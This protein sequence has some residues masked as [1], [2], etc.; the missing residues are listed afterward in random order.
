MPRTLA[1]ALEMLAE[2]APDGMPIAGGTNVI[3]DLRGGRYRPACL[4]NVAGLP[5]LGGIRQEDGILVIGGGVTVAEV[6]DDPLVA[7]YAPVLREAARTLASPLVRNRATVAGNLANASPAAD[8]APPLLVLDAEVELASRE[9]TRRVPLKDFFLGVR[10]T[11][12]QP[13]EL[14]TA[15]RIPLPPAHSRARFFKV[16]LRKANAIAVVNSAVRVDWEYGLGSREYGLGGR[17]YGWGGGLCRAARIALGAVAPTPIR[18]WEAERAL[19]GQ[20]LMPEVIA[21]AARLA[22][23]ATRTIDDIRG[24]AAY[25]RHVTEV[26]VRRALEG[27]WSRE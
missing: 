9:G 14:I 22:A 4:V 6:L 5:E 24:S 17:E 10:R 20:S 3:P 23:E 11:V 27:L 18:A 19:E 12:R 1:E 26:L 16:A 21:Q 7:R 8:M 2:R 15:I 13:H 25:R